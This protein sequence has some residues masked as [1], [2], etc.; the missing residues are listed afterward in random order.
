MA[1]YLTNGVP[2]WFAGYPANGGERVETAAI[3][4]VV[5]V[6]DTGDHGHG[7]ILRFAP[8][9]GDVHDPCGNRVPG[10]AEHFERAYPVPCAC[11]ISPPRLREH[12]RTRRPSRVT[13]ESAP[14]SGQ[15]KQA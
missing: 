7:P 8:R 2:S 6:R 5:A 9:L 11:C 12:A 1:E 3:G 10:F 4:A 15:R 13:G 14:F